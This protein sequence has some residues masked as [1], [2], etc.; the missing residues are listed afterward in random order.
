MTA[1]PLWTEWC[2]DVFHSGLAVLSAR[3]R[4][5]LLSKCRRTCP[6]RT[7]PQSVCVKMGLVVLGRAFPINSEDAKSISVETWTS[8]SSV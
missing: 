4:D 5:G 3:A 8:C 6:P 2:C 7:R 1:L